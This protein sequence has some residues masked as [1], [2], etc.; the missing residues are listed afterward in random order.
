MELAAGVGR[1]GED[2][3]HQR[4][5]GLRE[6]RGSIARECDGFRHR[7]AADPPVNRAKVRVII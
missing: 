3:A 6:H 7:S 1:I 4:V 5:V 2:P